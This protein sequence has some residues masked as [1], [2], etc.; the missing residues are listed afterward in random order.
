MGGI[1]FKDPLDGGIGFKEPKA[2]GG[3]EVASFFALRLS[4]EA[5][6]DRRKGS[7][8][9]K[10][11][12]M[13]Q[14]LWFVAQTIARAREGLPTTHFE[15]VCLA[16]TASN[17]SMFLFWWGKPLD[18]E[19]PLEVSGVPGCSALMDDDAVVDALAGTLIGG[20][21]SLP[22]GTWIY[23]SEGRVYPKPSPTSWS[24]GFKGGNGHSLGSTFTLALSLTSTC[25]GA[26][27]VIA[28][29]LP[30]PS[31]AEHLLW[32][33]CSLFLVLY[34]FQPVLFNPCFRFLIG[35]ESPKM[36]GEPVLVSIAL[37][38]SL[39]AM[40]YLATRLSLLVLPFVELRNLSLLVH[41]TVSWS[42]LIPHV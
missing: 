42:D 15:V 37:I 3:R 28:W 26:L 5:I 39:G 25:F 18:V 33:I 24:R 1:I 32:H 30:S 41:Q 6:A 20:L 14:V 16:F 27:H 9:G 8:L 21:D 12:V 31:R 34:P 35:S 17:F 23:C 22:I 10:T 29:S 4:E 2:W 36:L 13:M 11:L 40:T 38:S 19:H 7:A